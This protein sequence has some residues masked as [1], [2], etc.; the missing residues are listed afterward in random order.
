MYGH[1]YPVLE[2][3]CVQTN[4]DKSV[5]H[6][7]IIKNFSKRLVRFMTPGSDTTEGTEKTT[8]FVQMEEEKRDIRTIPFVTTLSPVR[9]VIRARQKGVGFDDVVFLQ[10]V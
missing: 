8:V 10:R 1:R 3:K 9:T 4:T 2:E 7:H 6:R 5:V